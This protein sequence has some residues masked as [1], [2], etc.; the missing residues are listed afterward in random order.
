MFNFSQQRVKI[1]GEFNSGTVYL[2]WLLTTNLKVKLLNELTLGWKRRVAPLPDEIQ[3]ELNEIPILFIVKSPYS[4]VLSMHRRPHTH[5]YLRKLKFSEFI[6]F[7]FG[8][9]R[10]PLKMWQKKA[11][12]YYEFCQKHENGILINYENLLEDPRIILDDIR[13]KFDIQKTSKWFR[14]TG[15]VLGSNRK[16]KDKSFHKSYYLKGY[17]QDDFSESNI[18]FVRTELDPE[19]MKKLDFRIL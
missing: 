5:E 2:E 10:T 13:K 16:T 12:S 3:G 9:Y 18:E 4:W 8:D 15:K 1:F 11:N 17:W 6:R 7:P 14:D 19:L